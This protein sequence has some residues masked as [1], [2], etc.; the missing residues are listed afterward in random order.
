MTVRAQV[1]TG[2]PPFGTFGG[3]PDVINLANLNSHITV[4][5]LNKAGRGQN[6]VYNI[7]YDSSVWNPLT[8]GSGKVWYPVTNW[9]FSVSLQAAFGYVNSTASVGTPCLSGGG[10]GG[11][12]Q[13]GTRTT[14]GWAYI[15]PNG[16]GHGFG[17]TVQVSGTCTGY[18]TTSIDVTASDGSGYTFSA[19]GATMTGLFNSKGQSINVPVN[20]PG[21]AAATVTD[22]NGNVISS[23]SSG[24][25]TDTLGTTA[26]S[27][28]GSQGSQVL[29][30][31]T[32]PS[33]G[34][35]SY[36]VN[37]TSYTVA[38]N[39]GVSGISEFGKTA[40][41]LVS[42]IV[43]PNG[44]QYTFTYEAT[45]STPSSGACTP[46]GGTYSANCVTAR[47]ASMQLPT[48][49]TITYQYSGG[50]NGI[51]SDGS[52]ATLTRTT[53][54]GAWTYAHSESGTAWTTTITDPQS[55]R[56][57]L[58]FQSIYETEEEDYS[59][60][61]TLLRT[62]YTCYNRA[63]PNCNS[64]AV[65]LPIA[66]Q[67]T[68]VQWPSGLESGTFLYYNIYGLPT[69]EGDYDYGGGSPGSLLRNT[70]I[71]YDTSL[72]NIV[73]AP[74]QITVS[75]SSGTTVAQT[76]YQ[77]DQ[78]AVTP[79]SGTPQHVSV[80][81]SRGNPT[82]ISYLTQGST[83]LSQ[84]FTYFDTGNVDV[85]TDVNTNPTTYAYGDCGNSFQTSANITTP[86][87][88]STSAVWNCNGGAP[89]STTD[90]NNQTTSYS[91]ETMWRLNKETFPD[92]G[93]T[94]YTYNDTPTPAS[95][96]TTI[97]IN[98]SSNEVMTTILDGLGRTKETQ[99]TSDPAGTDYV[100]TTYDSL[101]R[102]YSVSNPYRSTSDPTYGLAKYGYDAL[103][104]PNQ[105][106]DADGSS[107]SASYSA[108]CVTAIDEQSKNRE[109]CSDG[110]GR[111][112]S[113]VEN[114]GGLGYTTSY[115]YDVLGDL[116]SVTENGSSSRTFT[117]DGLSRLTSAANL[118]SGTV[119]YVYD[120]STK[121]DLYTKKDARGT[122]T[123]YTYDAL[124]RLTQ[125]AYSD[126]TPGAIYYYDQN[127]PFGYSVSNPVDRFVAE[128]TG[129]GTWAAWSAFTYDPMGRILG[130]REC[131]PPPVGS[132]QCGQAYTINQTY[133]LNGDM[134]SY[135]NGQNVTFTQTFNAAAQLTQL[136]SSYID[137]QHPGTLAVFNN[138]SPIG[139]VT[140]TSYGNGLTETAAFNNRLQPCRVNA[141]SSGTALSTCTAAIPSGNLLDLN[142]AWNAGTSDN[143]NVMGWTAAGNQSFNRSFTYDALN[144]V[145][146]MSDSDSVATCQ[147]LT[148]G[149]DAWGNR[150]AQTPTKGT[151]GSW[152]VS[153]SG[154]NQISG[155]TYDAA[156][157]VLNDTV[158][159]YTYDAE[160]RITQVDG[161]S[162]AAYLYDASGRRVEKTVGSTS[163]AFI[164]DLA[165]RIIADIQTPP[166]GW[167]AGYVYA[168]NQ[169]IAEYTNS[170]TY[171]VHPDHLG[172]TRL[173]T[174]VNQSIYDS[175]DFMP[176]G[177]Q[178]LGGTGTT[179]KFTGYPRDSE[180]DLDYATFRYNSSRQ[181]RFMSPDPYNFGA[182]LTNP[183]SWNGYAYVLNNPLALTDPLGLG[184]GDS[185]A[186]SQEGKTDGN[187][188]TCQCTPDEG[189][190]WIPNTTQSVTVN[191]NPPPWIPPITGP[192]ATALPG[193]GNT[194]PGG[195]SGSGFWQ[196]TVA[197]NRCAAKNAASLASIAHL[198]QNN[199]FVNAFAGNDAS[200]L[201]TLAFGPGRPQAA[202][203]LATNNPSPWSA[204]TLA[205]AAAGNIPV[206]TSYYAATGA[207][208]QTPY[209][210]AIDM[211]VFQPTISSTVGVAV[212]TGVAVFAVGK[213]IFDTGAYLYGEVGCAVK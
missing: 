127:D 98:S 163:T 11:I 20:P 29:L 34:S 79:T 196:R 155:Y 77:Y 75:N 70:V 119:T 69:Q 30:T 141:N 170:T 164:Y 28:T 171:F 68:Y 211:A 123:T 46:I 38:T 121:G 117:Y 130:Q 63:A 154:N 166:G 129:N 112:T 208:V 157:N 138:Y 78:T 175:M 67:S 59:G 72:G 165:G 167:W 183:Q 84:T 125:K 212:E 31:Y 101:G 180:S 108:N 201:S 116:T 17:S 6:F 122:T 74:A 83:T 10:I 132:A 120:T 178:I 199:F 213:F 35:S 56:T 202:A 147:G 190:A 194:N 48:G 71:S 151:C 7:T 184:P 26:L 159:S 51:L 60:S 2:T 193:G 187:G 102:V 144:R 206:G 197:V 182:N 85:A 45:P 118:E 39:F 1:Q 73:S 107:A 16:T 106:T 139:A 111:M 24:V 142:Y 49:G 192:L 136:T 14:Y 44:S 110:L 89:T 25:F 148:W 58:N 169:F 140:N 64:T 55:N 76:T 191:G 133:D 153:Y 207:V 66:V 65:T 41:S 54:D 128:W 173:M 100:D 181:G 150:T 210:P 21:F 27:I 204:T 177:E 105:I 209:G 135:T 179:H 200:A 162:T 185:C 62:V 186:S 188:N 88:M 82:T 115:G 149:Y 4:P 160:N 124:H 15:D 114:P 189:C 18:S 113:V 158:H 12:H 203:G 61:S 92:G 143:G 9:G 96:T 32:N 103:S 47:L 104:R 97:K 172:S 43:L 95:V 36:T 174:G 131:V 152:S 23:N 168:N 13:T 33:G 5:V 53:P 99:L 8:T 90:Q 126:G 176:F 57:V 19:I 109:S 80:S 137:S 87:S 205:G 37:Y 198:N 145:G 146:S 86:V 134:T 161:G 50:N 40:E 22:N 3:G 91:Y 52:T 94:S 195:G 93:E 81:G 156:G 42:S